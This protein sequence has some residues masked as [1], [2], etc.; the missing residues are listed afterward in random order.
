MR[1]EQ[2]PY[3]RQVFLLKNL[4]ARMIMSDRTGLYSLKGDITEQ[5]MD[6]FR[7]ALRLL[8]QFNLG[9][10]VSADSVDIQK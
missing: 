5:E 7:I 9:D 10:I 6:A 2:G 4:K 1:P 3:Y 8:E